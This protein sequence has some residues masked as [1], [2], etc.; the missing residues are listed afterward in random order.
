MIDPNDPK[1]LSEWETVSKQ[2]FKNFFINSPY[3][4]R[5]MEKMERR[6]VIIGWEVRCSYLGRNESFVIRDKFHLW[7]LDDA[8]PIISDEM[9]TI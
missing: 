3:P 2:Q 7:D 6:K 9:F 8:N 4:A 5:V 1:V